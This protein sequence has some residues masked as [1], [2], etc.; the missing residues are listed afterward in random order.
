MIYIVLDTNVIVSAFLEQS[1]YSVPLELLK[2]IF[3]HKEKI[4]IIYNDDI[5]EEY[6]EVLSRDKFN[7]KKSRIGKFIN[8]IKNIGKVLPL[9]EITEKM[10]DEDDVVFYQVLMEGKKTK[11]SYLVTGNLKHFPKKSYIVTPKQMLD[12]LNK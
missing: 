2:K 7:I 9:S 5:L 4:T 8:D 10:I 11:E 12:F 6:K 1:Q 3:V